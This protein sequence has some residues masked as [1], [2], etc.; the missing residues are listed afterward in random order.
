MEAS[1]LLLD[2][3]F[4]VH[5]RNLPSIDDIKSLSLED[6][7]KQS[8][9]DYGHPEPYEH[10]QGTES[11]PREE[12]ADEH[13]GAYGRRHRQEKVHCKNQL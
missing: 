12:V 5:G 6:K 13:Q 7:E 1:D 10:G 3:T 11:V 9:S 4:Y 8:R 2:V